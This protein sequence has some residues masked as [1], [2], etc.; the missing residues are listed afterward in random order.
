MGRYVRGELVRLSGTFEVGE[1]PVP[2]DPTVAT[3]R[4]REPDGSE[5]SLTYPGSLVRDSAGAFHHDLTVD[6]E[7]LWAYRFEGTAPAL[8]ANEGKLEVRSDF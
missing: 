5:S 7:G 1:P 6:A 3:L 4:I 2:T 8:G